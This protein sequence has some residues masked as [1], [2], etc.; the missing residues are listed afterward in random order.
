MLAIAPHK[1]GAIFLP[2]ADGNADRI[3]NSLETKGVGIRRVR[4][5]WL[6]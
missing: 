2:A 3:Q 1:R 4:E 6:G 5:Q